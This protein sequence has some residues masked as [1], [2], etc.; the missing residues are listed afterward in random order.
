MISDLIVSIVV[1]NRK[2]ILVNIY[3]PNVNISLASKLSTE[4]HSWVIF[5]L[6][7]FDF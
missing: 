3:C 6:R 1:M 5:V 2:Y 7:F 4:L